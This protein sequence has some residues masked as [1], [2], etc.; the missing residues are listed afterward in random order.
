M[1]SLAGM[2]TARRPR[3]LRPLGSELAAESRKRGIVLAHQTENREPE[4]AG[5][6]EPLLA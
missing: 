5:L 2:S 4:G 6:R 1:T 3:R